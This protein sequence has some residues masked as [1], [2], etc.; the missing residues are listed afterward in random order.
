M[1]DN[2]SSFEM[3]PP[4]ILQARAELFIS[5]SSERHKDIPK[6]VRLRISS[7]VAREL[8]GTGFPLE[9]VYPDVA[10]AG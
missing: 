5:G 6:D 3:M 9:Q 7:W 4:H 1:Q 8:T 10:A 2:Q